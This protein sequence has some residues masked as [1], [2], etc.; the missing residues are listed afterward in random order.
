MDTKTHT[1]AQITDTH[2][3]S[4]ELLYDREDTLANLAGALDALE[5]SGRSVDALLLTGDLADAGE[6]DAYR[7]IRSV[8]EPVAGRLGA[9]VLWGMGNHDERRAFRAG[10]L[11]AAPTDEPVDLVVDLGG[12]RLVMVDSTTP[13]AHDGALD[14]AQLAWLAE[15]LS[16]PA[17][18]GTV[19]TIHHPPLPAGDVLHELAGFRDRDPL[20]AVLGGSDV[21]VV[22]SGH[23]HNPVSGRIGGIPVWAGSATAMASDVLPTD[24][25]RGLQGC[26]F[27]LIDL[28]QD[29]SHTTQDVRV[30]DFHVVTELD[31]AELDR[32]ILEGVHS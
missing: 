28:Y 22:L 2:I 25:M 20:A 16:A 31:F 17:P 6:P 3:T 8:V 5:R 14:A 10:L 18:L 19:L 9:T 13:G 11:D 4:G 12:L 27:T 23:L 21:R 24:R 30:G 32:M 15:V 29:G 1:L 7:R 26:G